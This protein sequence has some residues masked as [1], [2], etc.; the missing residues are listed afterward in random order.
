M[1]TLSISEWQV[2]IY[3]QGKAGQSHTTHPTYQ[4]PFTK[5]VVA[6]NA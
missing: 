4:G 6:D 5:S 1:T 2:K 3:W